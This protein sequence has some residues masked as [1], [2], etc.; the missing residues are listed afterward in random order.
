MK[1]QNISSGTPWEKT[2]GYSRAVRVGDQVVVSGTTA[3]DENGV[4]QGIGDVYLQS[5]YIFAKIGRALEQ[6]GA[7][8]RDVVRVRMFVVDIGQLGGGRAHGEVFADILP[9]ITLRFANGAIGTIDNSRKAVYGYDQRVEVFG[10]AGSASSGNWY[11]DAVTVSTAAGVGRGLP[12]NFFLERYLASYQHEMA[13]FVRCVLEGSPSPVSGADGRAP[14]LIAG[15]A[16]RSLR[17][18]RPMRVGE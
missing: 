10:S 5:Q 14:V 7:S 2:V 6:A 13:A 16:L 17:E 12:L 9:M 1:R 18:N 3:S 8:L 15:A 4:V 11:A